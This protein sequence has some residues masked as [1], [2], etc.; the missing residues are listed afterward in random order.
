MAVDD[1]ECLVGIVNEKQGIT[2]AVCT[3][4]SA[5]TFI[6]KEMII[7]DMFLIDIETTFGSSLTEVYG[8]NLIKLRE[9]LLGKDFKLKIH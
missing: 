8:K 9:K 7:H 3:K 5:I 1:K 4:N 2:D 6:A